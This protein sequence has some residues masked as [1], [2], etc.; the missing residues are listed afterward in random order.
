M[1]WGAGQGGNMAKADLEIRINKP[2]TT[3]YPGDTLEGEVIVYRTS[4]QKKGTLRLQR[5]WK[6]HG[7]GNTAKGGESEVV[8][9]TAQ[10]GPGDQ[11]IYPFTMR[12]PN[13]P[14]TY[15]GELLN[16][17]WYLKAQLDVPWAIDPKTQL[18]FGVQ[19]GP[20]PPPAPAE[21]KDKVDAQ[22]GSKLATTPL[23]LV[24]AVFALA[25][26]VI[27]AG[28][29][30]DS[31]A[32]IFAVMFPG[33]FVLVGLALVSAALRNKM[34]AKKLGQ[35]NLSVLPLEVGPGQ[36]V[37]CHLHFVPKKAVSLNHITLFLTC[38]E[39]V[40]SGSGTN[41]T[42]HRNELHRQEKKLI[43]G[44]DLKR[45]MPFD[46]DATFTLPERGPL[47]FAGSDNDLIWQVKCEIDIDKWPDWN[48]AIP[49]VVWPQRA[50][51]SVPL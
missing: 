36:E 15:H 42:T 18:S 14:F 46:Q 16:V 25:G 1:Q 41:R 13:G 49:F 37:A 8:L 33:V 34:A 48:K 38:Q 19:P 47:S 32:P 17:D 12:V 29:M 9:K 21:L 39:V 27:M 43:S 3:F 23:V 40:V 4:D 2:D 50:L 28:A 30:M 44:R 11:E 5:F 6:T 51:S 35:V 22:R 31:D 7:R 20:E 26:G 10:V 45:G 24:G